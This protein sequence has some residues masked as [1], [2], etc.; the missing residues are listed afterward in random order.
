METKKKDDERNTNEKHEAGRFI[1]HIQDAKKLR[2]YAVAVTKA[3]SALVEPH[4]AT[5]TAST[6]TP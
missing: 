6:W 1:Y 5:P 3:G 4:D 2:C